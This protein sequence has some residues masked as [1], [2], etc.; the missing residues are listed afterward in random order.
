[1][2]MYVMKWKNIMFCKNV[3]NEVIYI[4]KVLVNWKSCF[5]VNLMNIE[6]LFNVIKKYIVVFFFLKYWLC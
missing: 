5:I 1:M 4:S 3:V 6:W 2:Y